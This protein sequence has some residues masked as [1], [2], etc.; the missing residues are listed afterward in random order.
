MS[1]V[2]GEHVVS[3]ALVTL[4]ALCGSWEREKARREEGRSEKTDRDQEDG[5]QDSEAEEMDSAEPQDVA[6]AREEIGT[7]LKER[8]RTMALKVSPSNPIHLHL[9]G[10]YLS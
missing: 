6:L 3:Y 7:L 2:P 9:L 10:F 8:R 4:T 1:L 5:E